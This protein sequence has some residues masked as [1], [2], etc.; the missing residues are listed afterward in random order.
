VTTKSHAD[1]GQV[2]VYSATVGGVECF[3]GTAVT[4]V[5]GDKMLAVVSDVEGATRWSSAGITDAKLLSDASGR[6]EYFQ[7]LDVPAW[8]LASDRFWFLTSTIERSEAS[9]AFR[10]DRLADGG[11]HKATW[12]KI[13]SDNPSAIEPPINVGG[14]YFEK[15]SDG[16]HV[17]YQVCTDT[18]GAIP[19][20][21][22][23]AATKKTL[24]DTLGDVVRAA[25]TR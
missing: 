16:T 18:G 13:K 20:A 3:R 11:D 19:A 25:R 10:W 15:A 2:T 1:A 7:Y 17:T 14:W 4:D 23:N 24:P 22:Q 5:A 12:E 6:I 8:T 9:I 21:V